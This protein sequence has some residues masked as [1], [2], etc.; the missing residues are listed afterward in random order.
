MVKEIKRHILASPFR[1]FTLIMS[2]GQRYKVPTADH[3]GFSPTGTQAVIWFN[4]GSSVIL[5]AIHMTAI[6]TEGDI[7][8][9]VR[10]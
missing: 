4:D 9:T 7:G 3:A 2:S 10:V 5:S 6:E 1:P 8:Q